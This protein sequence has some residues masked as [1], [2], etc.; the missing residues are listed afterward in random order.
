MNTAEISVI[1]VNWNTRQLL[2]DCLN[3]IF[4]TSGPL[5]VEVI[6]VDNASTDGSKE[7]LQADFPQVRLIENQQNVGFAR[8]NNQAMSICRGKKVMLLNSDTVIVGSA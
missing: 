5:N 3:S 4:A 7:M 8:A 6:V 1:I 2:A